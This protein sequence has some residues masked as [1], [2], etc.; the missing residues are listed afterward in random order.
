MGSSSVRSQELWPSWGQAL[1]VG[2]RDDPFFFFFKQFLLK[3][4][5]VDDAVCPTNP[6]EKY[7]RR[8]ESEGRA[9]WVS[10]KA[11]FLVFLQQRHFPATAMPHT[12]QLFQ[13]NCWAC[14]WWS[15]HEKMVV[16]AG[17]PRQS[18]DKTQ[19]TNCLCTWVE[20][21]PKQ[22]GTFVEKDKMLIN[23]SNESRC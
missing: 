18:R 16:G 6:C 14:I 1:T 7:P 8:E 23:S 2:Y 10:I 4:G 20:I 17:E 19:R 13:V 22:V 5:E 11:S 9:R 21:L 12:T 15:S 3:T